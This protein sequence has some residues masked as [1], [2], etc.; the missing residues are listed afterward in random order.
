[1]E[2][3][4]TVLPA[5][6]A[7][8]ADVT[9]VLTAVQRTESDLNYLVSE[10]EV[11][12]PTAVTGVATNNFTLSVRQL[13]AGSV[14]STFASVTFGAGTN[15][16]AETPLVVPVSTPPAFQQDD[17]IDVLLHQNGTGLAVPAGLVVEL[18]LL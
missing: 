2:S 13:R 11:L 12:S 17:V 1:M 10:V 14:V 8:A 16:A 7:A 9:T 4:K 3:L 18:Q 5:Q 15:L 6:A